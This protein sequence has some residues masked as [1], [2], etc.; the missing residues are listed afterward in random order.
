[1]K[2]L[3]YIIGSILGAAGGF[4]YYHFV[5][6]KTGTCPIVSDPYISIIFGA[7]V[8]VL[9]ADTIADFVKEKKSI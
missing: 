8:G 9:I 6:C 7:I 5:G 2:I 1:M 3:V 4:S